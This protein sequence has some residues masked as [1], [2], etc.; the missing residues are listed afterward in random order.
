MN[1]MIVLHTI[2]I[3]TCL[4]EQS[5]YIIYFFYVRGKIKIQYSSLIYVQCNNNN[6]NICNIADTKSDHIPD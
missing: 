5:L 6:N 3:G 4:T 2:Y 1:M